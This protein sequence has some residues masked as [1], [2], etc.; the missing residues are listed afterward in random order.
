MRP[1]CVHEEKYDLAA[2]NSI[3]TPINRS[4]TAISSAAEALASTAP[5]TNG[6]FNITNISVIIRTKKE[7]A[8]L[9]PL[10]YF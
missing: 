8:F 3:N 9:Q 4:M 10:L 6:T 5:S 7:T 2:F 1:N